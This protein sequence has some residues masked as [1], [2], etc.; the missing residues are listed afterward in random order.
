MLSLF[1]KCWRLIYIHYVFLHYDLDA[2]IWLSPER[3]RLKWL[4]LFLPWRWFKP[5]TPPTGEQLCQALETLGPI[6]VKA[7]Q[8]LSI[9]RDFLPESI[10][11]ALTK[12]QDNVQPFSSDIAIQ[13]IEKAFKAPIND[14]FK[15]V[16]LIP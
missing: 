11:D 13:L 1:K 9:R 4:M 2:L 16:D 15:Q 14:C 6:F 10:A 7:G 5:I 3:Q 12:L 8:L